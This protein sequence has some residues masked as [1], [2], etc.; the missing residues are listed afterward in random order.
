MASDGLRLLKAFPLFGSGLGTFYAGLS[1]IRVQSLAWTH[2]HNDYLEVL[3]ELGVIRSIGL[4]AAVWYVVRRQF[5]ALS[6]SNERQTRLFAIGSIGAIGAALLHAVGEFNLF[7]PANAMAL[8][9]LM[10]ISLDR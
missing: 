2:A 5:S 10:G 4:A 3:I 9:W 7:V 6:L 8:A 1:C